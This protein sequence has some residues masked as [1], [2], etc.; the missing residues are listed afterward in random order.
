MNHGPMTSPFYA[1]RLTWDESVKEAGLIHPTDLV[2][3]GKGK[4]GKNPETCWEKMSALLESE[5]GGGD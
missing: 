1:R 5:K 2:L 3:L 4:K